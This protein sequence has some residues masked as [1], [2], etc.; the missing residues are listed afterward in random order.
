M[1]QMEYNVL[2][3]EYLEKLVHENEI[4][5]ERPSRI[6]ESNIGKKADYMTI[7]KNRI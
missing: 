7:E 3:W 2:F 1:K 6:Y 5:I 4:I